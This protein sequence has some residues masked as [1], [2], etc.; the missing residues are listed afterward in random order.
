M[1]NKKSLRAIKNDTVL[2]GIKSKIK[3][4]I[5]LFIV[6]Y[7]FATLTACDG[8][9]KKPDNKLKASPCAC[10]EVVYDSKVS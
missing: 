5:K 7:F 4:T 10:N 2:N 1:I 6:L 3:I 8:Y 9:Y